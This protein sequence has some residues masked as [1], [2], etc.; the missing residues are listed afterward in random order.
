MH[1]SLT[2]GLTVV[3]LWLTLSPKPFGDTALLLFPGQDKVAHALMFFVWTWL[4]SMNVRDFFGRFSTPGAIGALICCFVLG[5]LI[6]EAQ[7]EM[8]LGRSFECADLVADTAGGGVAVISFAIASRILMKKR[9]ESG[10]E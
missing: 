5:G 8:N 7:A 9:N 6:E 2:L 10:R 3:I 4:V 1:L